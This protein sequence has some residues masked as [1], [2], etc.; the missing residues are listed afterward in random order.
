MIEQPIEGLSCPT[1]SAFGKIECI[2][3][4]VDHHIADLLE[5]TTAVKK[6]SYDPSLAISDATIAVSPA[7][8]PLTLVWERL[9]MPTTIPP[10]T[11]AISPAK[12]GGNS[13]PA[14]RE[15]N[16]TPKQSGKATRKTTNPAMTSLAKE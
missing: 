7:A 12:S 2:V 6:D 14:G 4:T 10:T 16:A 11:H 9:M 3:G 5:G 8:G 15:A 13:P 1:G